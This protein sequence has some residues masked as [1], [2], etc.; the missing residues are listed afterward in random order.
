MNLLA[1]SKMLHLDTL[2]ESRMFIYMH[3]SYRQFSSGRVE[4]RHLQ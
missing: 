2:Y 1:E 4:V 3:P